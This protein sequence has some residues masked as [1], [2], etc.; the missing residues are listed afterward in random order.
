MTPNYKQDETQLKSIMSKH[1]KPCDPTNKIKLIIYYKSKKLF[2]LFIKNNIHAKTS[3]ISR[4]HHVVYEY[5]C[6]RD[7]CNATQKYIGYTT[8][9][10]ADRF[11][12][13]T[14]NSSSI[15]KHLMERHNITKVT[16]K[17]LLI[18]VNILRSTLD[19]RDL[20]F[21]EALLVKQ[22]K[23]TLNSQIEFSDKL[24]KVFRH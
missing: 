18:N 13:H 3:E 24:L 14:Q 19:K 23:P 15:K 20:L 12:M 7:G 17:E 11:R 8:C 4:Q 1:T 22:S 5:S 6:P 9:A 10:V 2:N 21:Y 16:T